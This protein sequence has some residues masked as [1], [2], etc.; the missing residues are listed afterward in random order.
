MQVAG[1]EVEEHQ[2]EQEV[3]VVEVVGLGQ[4]H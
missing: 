3:E 1:Q 4:M 2:R